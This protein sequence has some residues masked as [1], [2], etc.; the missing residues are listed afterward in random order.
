M[1]NLTSGLIAVII[2]SLFVGGLA[3]SIWAGT[4]SI[5]FPIIAIIVL[6]MIYIDVWQTLRRK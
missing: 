4:G 5:A 3:H 2:V 1:M 6:V